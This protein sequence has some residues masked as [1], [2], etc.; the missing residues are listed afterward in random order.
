MENNIYTNCQLILDKIYLITSKSHVREKLHYCPICK[1]S[2][3]KIYHNDNLYIKEALIHSLTDHKSINDHLYRK[4]CDFKLNNYPISW[5][6]FDT[7]GINIIDGLYDVGSTEIYIKT[8]NFY[9]KTLYSEHAGFIYFKDGKL[10]RINVLTGY[11]VD[12]GD[13]TIFLPKNAKETFN[14]DYVFHTHPTTPF[15]G[16]R[17]THNIIYEFPSVSDILHFVEHH[18]NGKL[19]GSLIVAP[20]GIYIIRK[21]N[22]NENKIKIDYSLFV[23]KLLK[24]YRKC[25]LDSM[26]QY[27][28]IKTKK[29]DGEILI[30][31]KEFYG[32]ISTNFEYIDRVN[33]FLMEYDIYIDYY[34]RSEIK[35]N[36]WTFK[37]IYI[38]F[39]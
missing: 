15:I 39:L 5:Y 1:K 16:S 30:P 36:I 24:V 11:R 27:S 9:G 19:L 6:N 38:P 12:D 25:Y 7:N 3:K 29:I 37:D 20:E 10:D 22:F 31:K 21:N 4:I 33:D 13:P 14:V 8:N 18:N 26:D 17:M 2:F 35:K 34:P 28:Y 32:N 23:S